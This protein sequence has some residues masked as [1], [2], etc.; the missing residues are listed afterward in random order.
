MNLS[1]PERLLQESDAGEDRF[2]VCGSAEFRANRL[3][4]GPLLSAQSFYR[5][6]G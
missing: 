3:G 4:S 1:R 6:S 5:L 2:D